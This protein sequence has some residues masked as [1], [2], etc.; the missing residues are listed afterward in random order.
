MAH[1]PYLG[2]LV[3]WAAPGCLGRN[4]HGS[5][6]GKWEALQKSGTGLEGHGIL[7]TC[8]LL[9]HDRISTL[10]GPDISQSLSLMHV[11][12]L[13]K[14]YNRWH[15]NSLPPRTDLSRDI[16]LNRARKGCASIPAGGMQGPECPPS[17]CPVT[18]PF[19]LTAAL[20]H[21][22]HPNFRLLQG[23]PQPAK[24]QTSYLLPDIKRDVQRLL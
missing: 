14:Q 20:R 18:F 5:G 8:F 1:S 9:P 15:Q 7:I 16:R 17:P 13:K 21:L 3:R 4:H 11:H 2:C 23:N 19:S 10:L 6:N 12:A 24:E 22:S